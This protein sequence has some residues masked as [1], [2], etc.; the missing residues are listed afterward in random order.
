MMRGGYLRVGD[1]IAMRYVASI[2]LFGAMCFAEQ[3]RKPV[4]NASN[5]GQFWPEEA[6]TSRDAARQLYQRGELEMCSLAVWKYKWEHISVNVRDL[7]KA[8]RPSTSEPRKTGAE[9]SR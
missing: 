9:E 8:R 7:A 2:I 4:C 6:N 5:Q 1:N 3:A